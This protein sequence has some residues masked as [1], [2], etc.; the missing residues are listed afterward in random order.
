[1]Y[2]SFVRYKFAY[3]LQLQYTLTLCS[4]YHQLQSVNCLSTL[5]VL[6]RGTSTTMHSFASLQRGTMNVPAIKGKGSR[7]RSLSEN[8]LEHKPT[9]TVRS[10]DILQPQIKKK[11]TVSTPRPKD[12]R[13]K[14]VDRY[15]LQHQEEDSMGDVKTALFKVCTVLH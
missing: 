11:K 5:Y 4:T 10:G 9:T 1:M 6:T 14:Q 2:G 13:S 7:K 3:H 8:W 12:F 15:C